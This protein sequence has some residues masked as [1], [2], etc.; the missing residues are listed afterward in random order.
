[1][2]HLVAD[3]TSHKTRFSYRSSN[4]LHFLVF[5]SDNDRT[6]PLCQITSILNGGLNWKHNFIGLP[7]VSRPADMAIEAVGGFGWP[8][9]P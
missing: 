4:G 3:F 1:L 2:H 6:R 5:S 7:V 8:E 9:E